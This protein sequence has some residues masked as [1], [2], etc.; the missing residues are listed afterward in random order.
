MAEHGEVRRGY[1]AGLG[2]E[3]LAEFLGT[4]VLI[5]LGTASVAVSLVGLPTSGRQTDPFGPANWLIIG[6]GWGLAVVFGIYVAGGITGAHIN[7]AVT[8]A[9]AVRR[10][11]S[12]A[13][14]LPYWV[15]QVAGAFVAA[16]LTFAVYHESISAFDAK[17]QTPRSASL[18]TFSIFATFPSEVFGGG[19]WGPLIDQIVGTGILVLLVF[20]IIDLKN[21][22]PGANLAPFMIGLVVVAIGFTF[23]TNAGYAINPARDFGPRLWAWI[24]GWDAIAL[25]GNFDW[26]TS[27]WWIP[28]VGPLI[29]AV[30]GAVL[31]DV[32]ISKTVVARGGVTEPGRVPTEESQSGD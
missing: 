30:I 25:P 6:W 16:M 9:F 5:L 22:G 13:K 27:Y 4:F 18:N 11:F 7:P 23:G 21:T 2:G 20:A 26:Y 28:I 19:I 14:V 31:Y 1:R 29:G 8:L 24:A 12:W 32:C 3:M 15:A 10:G 17:A